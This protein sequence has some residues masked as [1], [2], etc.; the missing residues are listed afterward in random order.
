MID[1][2]EDWRECCR[3][4]AN[5]SAIHHWASDQIEHDDNELLE[6]IHTRLLPRRG[7]WAKP[8]EIL[9]TV[10]A[11][12]AIFLAASPL[13]QHNKVGGVENPGYYDAINTLFHP[14]LL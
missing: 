6:Q 13:L 3:E 1:P 5:L 2:V 11:Q 9:V 14:Y 8:D 12:N 10:G 4:A 7:I